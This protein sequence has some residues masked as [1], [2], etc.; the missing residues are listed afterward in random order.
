MSVKSN[1]IELC[2]FMRSVFE[3]VKLKGRRASNLKLLI[4]RVCGFCR[5]ASDMMCS[6]CEW[7][8]AGG[9][10]AAR[11]ARRLLNYLRVICLRARTARPR[12]CRQRGVTLKIDELMNE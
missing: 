7:R 1:F 2:T 12:R 9:S 3:N 6:E 8:V 5:R 4:N 11:V 10:V